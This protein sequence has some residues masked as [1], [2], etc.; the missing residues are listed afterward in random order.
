MDFK[1]CKADEAKQQN[2]KPYN[3]SCM[4]FIVADF[5]F[6]RESAKRNKQKNVA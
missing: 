5:E 6:K 3:K 4:Q 1:I 2:G